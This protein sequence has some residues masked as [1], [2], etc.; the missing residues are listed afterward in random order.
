MLSTVV[1]DDF[2]GDTLALSLGGS[3]EFARETLDSFGQLALLVGAAQP[4]RFVEVA[5]DTVDA[6]LSAW[7]ERARDWPLPADLRARLDQHLE[8]VPLARR[9]LQSAQG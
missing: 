7:R 3:R 5:A 2:R 9:R 6:L 1:Y 4:E 8:R